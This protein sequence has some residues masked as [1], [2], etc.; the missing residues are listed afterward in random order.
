[1]QIP[2]KIITINTSTSRTYY[3]PDYVVPLIRALWTGAIDNVFKDI[4]VADADPKNKYQQ[5]L[6]TREFTGTI[7]EL[8]AFEEQRL[9]AQYGV[10]PR[11]K[12]LLFDIVYP[13][14]SFR[15]AVTALLG[16][17]VQDDE[18]TTS[19]IA[20]LLD[21]GIPEGDAT[22][23]AG[24]G[25]FTAESLAQCSIG[26]L[27]PLPSIGRVK[28]QRYIDAAAAKVHGPAWSD[29]EPPEAPESEAAL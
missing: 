10:N 16:E 11:T 2:N 7:E 29:E 3:E 20:E 23:L 4:T 12:S 14:N 6:S 27:V 22:I 9:R 5:A 24:G 15:A 13:G 28:A 26:D 17:V 1:M 19:P 8:L 21:L 25:F 18:D